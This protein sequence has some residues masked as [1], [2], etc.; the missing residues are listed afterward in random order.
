MYTSYTGITLTILITG[1][2]RTVTLDIV[3]CSKR[4]SY[5]AYHVFVQLV[6]QVSKIDEELTIF[7]PY[8]NLSV[9][10]EITEFDDKHSSVI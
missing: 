2:Q 3:L 7:T 5:L 6:F 8:L 1:D 4:E 10:M 9:N